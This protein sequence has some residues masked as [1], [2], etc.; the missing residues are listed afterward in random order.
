MLEDA[1]IITFVPVIDVAKVRRLYIDPLGL[2]VTDESPFAPVVDAIGTVLRL[3]PVTDLGPPTL[4]SR[5]M[6]CRRYR[7][8]GH[9]LGVT[10]TRYDGIDRD[11]LRGSGR[12][13]VATEWLSSPTP[14]PTCCR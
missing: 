10:F 9:R 8:D 6:V 3:T 12:H 11:P 7:N 1:P 14:T 4:H 2:T 13:R 5:R